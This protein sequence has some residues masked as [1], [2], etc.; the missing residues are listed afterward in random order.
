MNQNTTESYCSKALLK[1]DE[2]IPR[3]KIYNKSLYKNAFEMSQCAPP[4]P[5]QFDQ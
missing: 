4:R 2:G 3:K 1:D 5:I